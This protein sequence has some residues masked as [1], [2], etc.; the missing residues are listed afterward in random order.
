MKQTNKQTVFF[1]DAAGNWFM[2]LIDLKD[3][4]SRVHSLGTKYGSSADMLLSEMMANVLE[5]AREKRIDLTNGLVIT[6]YGCGRSKAANV[7]GKVLAEKASEVALMLQKGKTMSEL[8]DILTPALQ[9]ENSIEVK[10]LSQIEVYNDLITVQR[11]D[12]GVKEFST[13]LNNRAD[14]TFCN[15]VFE[16]IP[17]VDLPAFIADLEATGKYIFASISLRDAVNY[18]PLEEALV[19]DGARMVNAVPQDAIVL[20]KDASGAYIFSLH[21]S[22]LPKAVWQEILGNRWHLLPAQDYTACSAVNF[23]PSADYQAYKKELIAKVG[24]A[25]FI[26]F[27]TP[28]GTRY[29]SD[30]ILFKRVAMMQPA[31]HIMKLQTLTEYPD[32]PFKAAETAK[33]ANFLKYVGL[34][35]DTDGVY[36]LSELPWDYLNKLYRLEKESKK[37]IEEKN[38][39]NQ[40]VQEQAEELI[41]EYNGK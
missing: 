10:T 29:E 7:V 41:K 6:D 14:I 19:M 12:I 31:K 26:A 15:D 21:V 5:L 11:F 8:M 27:P 33:S 35:P 25:D 38:N 34:Q 1:K 4:Y 40:M 16:H 13:P 2:N 30:P 24:F 9:A 17:K 3:V 23:E 28:V 18:S 32:S 37:G 36:R 20:E 39:V 22:V